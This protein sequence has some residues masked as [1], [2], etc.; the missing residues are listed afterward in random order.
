MPAVGI[1]VVAAER[2]DFDAVHQH[3]AELR[4]HQLSPGKQ[5][6]QLFRPRVGRDII[7][8]RFAPQEQVAHAAADQPS[9]EAV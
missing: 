8:L 9:L 3:H 1:G 6:Q 5:P 4:A 2:G 7:V